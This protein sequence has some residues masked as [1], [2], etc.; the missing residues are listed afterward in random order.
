MDDAR[1]LLA[2][3]VGHLAEGTP[4]PCPGDDHLQSLR[5]VDACIRSS[6]G[7]ETVS[8]LEEE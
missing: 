1:R 4:L 6:S 3:F 5:M 2:D 7:E 8:L